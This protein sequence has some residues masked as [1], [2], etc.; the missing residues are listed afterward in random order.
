MLS[1]RVQ[2]PVTLWAVAIRSSVHGI[3]QARILGWVAI[4][5]SRASPWPGDQ[6]CISCIGRH[7]LYHRATWEVSFLSLYSVPITPTFSIPSKMEHSRRDHKGTSNTSPL[8]WKCV[9]WSLERKEKLQ[10][11]LCKV[12]QSRTK[13]FWILVHFPVIPKSDCAEYHQEH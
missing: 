7:I 2:L 1:H 6:T 9:R 3:L 13:S 4:S 11:V 8:Y 5:S 10:R 12:S